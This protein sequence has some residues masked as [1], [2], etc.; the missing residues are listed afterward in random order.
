MRRR[1]AILPFTMDSDWI[2]AAVPLT[3]T[4]QVTRLPALSSGGV[5]ASCCQQPSQ[6]V[7]RE[8]VDGCAGDALCA[9]AAPAATSITAVVV[10]RILPAPMAP[11][12]LTMLR[13]GYRLSQGHRS[14]CLDGP[15]PLH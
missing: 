8:S 14:A 2:A 10:R 5:A 4:L 13:I 7:H 6:G 12:S 11:S 1:D 9:R 3:G 15:A